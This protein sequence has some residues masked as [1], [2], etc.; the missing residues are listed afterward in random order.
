MTTQAFT[1]RFKN[2]ALIDVPARQRK[3]INPL[4]L[5]ELMKDI[6]ENGL[7][8][9][10]VLRDS[11]KLVAGE[12]R[13]RA[14]SKLHVE[15][16]PFTYN[17]QVVPENCVPFI[18]IEAKDE[19]QALQ[20]ELNE[21]LLREDLSWQDRVRA[22]SDL[23]KLRLAQNPKQT[24]KTTAEEIVAKTNSGN[25]KS[26]QEEI[27]RSMVTSEFLDDPDVRAAKNERWAFNM[28]A[29]KMRDEFASKLG[30]NVKSRHTFIPGDAL[31]KLEILIEEKKK[32][33]C[34]IIDPPYGID[35]HTFHP[36]N[37]PAE[38][39]HEYKDDL[40]SSLL[41]SECLFFLCSRLATPD[42][43]L[44]MFCDVELFLTLREAGRENGWT[45]FRTPIIW[46]KGSIG[47]ILRKANIRR[48][49]EMLLFAQ[50]SET[51]GLSQ[52]MQDVISISSREEDKLHAAQKPTGLYELLI[53]LS[54]LPNDTV[55]DPCCG[56]GTIFRASQAIK[57]SATGIEQDENFIK[58][59]TNLL[60]ELE[61][62]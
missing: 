13:L 23:Q 35:A 28:A 49:Y 61:T 48:G 17:L 27:S 18:D 11:N 1:T 12:R 24:F 20:M 22:Q 51:R 50:R 29:R 54:C 57:V 15:K 62:Q 16:I 45:V 3:T 46:N 4:A 5:E 10:I 30:K 52:V 26:V 2:L 9:A 33:N 42:A 34:F 8:H 47:Y 7:L 39:L 14:M 53:R 32:F 19:I 40:K 59:C 55:L 43:H 21:N 6:A 60:V 31:E 58:I 38:K 56:S 41:F 44:W 37:S 25:V 36:G